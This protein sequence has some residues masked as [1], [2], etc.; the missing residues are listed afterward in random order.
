[1]NGWKCETRG[2]TASNDFR[3]PVRCVGTLA[4]GTIANLY[5]PA[6]SEMGE[7]GCGRSSPMPGYVNI[8]V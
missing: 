2:L 8:P 3:L 5:A 1:M 4:D 6:K 7:F